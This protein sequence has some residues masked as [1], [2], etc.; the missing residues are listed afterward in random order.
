MPLKDGRICISVDCKCGNKTNIF[1][2]TFGSYCLTCGREVL[3]AGHTEEINDEIREVVHS[4]RMRLRKDKKKGSFV[5]DD[6]SV[7]SASFLSSCSQCKSPLSPDGVFVVDG[8]PVCKH[9]YGSIIPTCKGCGERH[10]KQY[11]KNG[12]CGG[13]IESFG[14]CPTCKATYDKRKTRTFDI[15]GKTFCNQC[16]DRY[17][18]AK[19]IEYKS[20]SYKPTPIFFGDRETSQNRYYGLEVEMDN[21]NRRNEFMAKAATDEIYFKSDGSLSN[22]VEV[23][24]HPATLNYHTTDF[25]WDNILRSAKSCGFKSHQG[26]SGNDHPTCGLHIHTSKKAFGTTLQEYDMRTAKLLILFDKFWKQL[27]VFSRR[28]RSSLESWAKRYATF[29]ITKDRLEEII[30]KAKGEGSRQGKYLAVNMRPSSTI[31]FR[32]FRGSL[33]KETIL[34]SIQL[35]E[36]MI[37]ITLESTEYVQSLTWERF[38]EIGCEKYPEFKGYIT[39]LRGM[40]KKI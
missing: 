37:D 13:C 38:C 39:R 23:V 8:E 21:S 15:G 12:L 35:I 3:V 27:V 2:G 14:N 4:E 7:G 26:S 25:P 36:L 34:A 1:S 11:L 20:Y 19:G 16:V 17:L 31:E 29:D 40:N 33:N 22:G 24:T 30:V 28:D 6:Y 18:H 5:K 9:C 10:F 32:L